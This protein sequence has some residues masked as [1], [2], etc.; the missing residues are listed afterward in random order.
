MDAG[1]SDSR[2]SYSYSKRFLW[3]VNLG[4]SQTGDL[5]GLLIE[6]NKPLAA[7]SRGSGSCFGIGLVG[8][9]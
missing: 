5:V 2:F 8:L 7:V 1:L 6:A 9:I 4:Q 3:R